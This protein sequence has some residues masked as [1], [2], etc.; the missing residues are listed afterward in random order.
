MSK[1]NDLYYLIIYHYTDDTLSL[2]WLPYVEY[3]K[4]EVVEFAREQRVMLGSGCSFVEI[5]EAD[6]SQFD[7]I[8]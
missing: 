6:I 8:S 1:F 5:S 4:S 7:I 3:S 2:E